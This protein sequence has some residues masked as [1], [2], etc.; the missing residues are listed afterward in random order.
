MR[1]A[2]KPVSK[3]TFWFCGEMEID[4]QVKSS[5]SFANIFKTLMEKN[6]G[7]INNSNIYNYFHR[8]SFWLF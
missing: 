2:L 1:K 5:Q 4:R 6:N 8:A 3:H 7:D